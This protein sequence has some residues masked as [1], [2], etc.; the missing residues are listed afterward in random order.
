MSSV[1]MPWRQSL[2]ELRAEH[3]AASRMHE[4]DPRD[5]QAALA[6]IHAATKLELAKRDVWIGDVVRLASPECRGVLQLHNHEPYLSVQTGPAPEDRVTVTDL[7]ALEAEPAWGPPES[8]SGHGIE[9]LAAGLAASEAVARITAQMIR[10][11]HG[12]EVFYGDSRLVVLELVAR[13]LAKPD[14]AW[15]N[16]LVDQHLMRALCVQ[17][18]RN[19][20]QFDLPGSEQEWFALEL[21]EAYLQEFRPQAVVRGD[22]GQPG[23]T[24]RLTN[25]RRASA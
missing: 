25:E 22:L 24:D 6:H 21:L 4:A 15:R 7:S 19:G 9:Q 17:M 23:G 3:A 1:S 12:V 11:G 2:D 8:L 13:Y 14:Y 10:A 20:S 18:T 16:G 5:Q